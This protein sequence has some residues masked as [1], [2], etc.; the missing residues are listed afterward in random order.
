MARPRKDP[1]S[2]DQQPDDIPLPEGDME[3][4]HD[5]EVDP[6]EM[7]APWRKAY[8]RAVKIGCT[9]KAARLYADAHERDFEPKEGPEITLAGIQEE[10]ERLQAKAE[11]LAS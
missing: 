2:V 6:D 3:A 10:I 8:E 5:A 1:V 9:E 11:K 4:E 7:P